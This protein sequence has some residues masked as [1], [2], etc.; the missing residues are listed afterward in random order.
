MS[1]TKAAL[2]RECVFFPYSP[3][4]PKKDDVVI[5]H[6]SSDSTIMSITSYGNSRPQTTR[7]ASR[8]GY[9]MSC[10]EG[11]LDDIAREVGQLL[12][13]DD[14]RIEVASSIIESTEGIGVERWEE[15]LTRLRK[16][17]SSR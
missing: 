9:T 3:I 8:W 17:A 6:L 5:S 14:V 2:D 12:G 15:F 1:R 16:I 10:R 13:V 7:A 11:I 4:S